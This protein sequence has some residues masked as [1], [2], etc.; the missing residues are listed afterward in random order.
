VYEYEMV[1]EPTKDWCHPGYCVPAIKGEVQNADGSPVARY[2]VTV[3]LVSPTFGT[4]WCAVG[5]ENK[6]LQPGEFKFETTTGEFPEL[7]TL[8]VVRS[9]GDPT[10]LSQ[11]YEIKG[12]SVKA[13]HYGIVFRHK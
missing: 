8:T 1:Q 9:Q 6:V 7:Y 2:A 5:D 10:P 4:Q 12:V 3:K 13:N 11:T